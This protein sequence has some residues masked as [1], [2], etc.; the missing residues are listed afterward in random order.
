MDSQ[1]ELSCTERKERFQGRR[2]D[3]S[4]LNK[5]MFP[6][7]VGYAFSLIFKPSEIE[8]KEISKYPNT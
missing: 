1:L 5:E 4:N 8:Q 7:V 3:V 2:R 6:Y